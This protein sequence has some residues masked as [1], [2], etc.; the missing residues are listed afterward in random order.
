MSRLFFFLLLLVSFNTVAFSQA[1]PDSSTHAIT[2]TSLRL[3][4]YVLNDSLPYTD[5]LR[6]EAVSPNPHLGISWQPDTVFAIG[7]TQFVWDI[8]KHH[9]FL[10]FGASPNFL[11]RQETDM[12]HVTGKDW[13]FYLLVLLLILFS[14][15]K[16]AFP[17]YFSDLFRVFF[18]TT[19]KQRQISEQLAQTPFPSLLLN[20]FF[21]VNAGLYISLLFN[22]Y[23]I[24]PADNFW[25]L[26]LY[27]CL[28]L[29]AIYFVKFIGLKIAGWLFSMKEATYSY[30]FIVFVVNKVIG[31]ILFPFL[32]LLAFS[33]GN[34]YAASLTISWCMLAGMLA[35]RVILTFAAIRN[36]VSINP[37][38][39][40]LYL[41]AFEIAP[42][43]LIYKALLEILSIT[44]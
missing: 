43:L 16:N 5:S 18:R 25:L 20:G 14:F 29:A 7:S 41:V 1:A 12:H 3:Q 35:Y 24:N 19:L 39:F 30:I 10:G 2:D 22:H 34:V 32:I 26:F 15:L 28:G 44:P 27:C 36:Q 23:G 33:Q 38:H 37:F 4:P 8:L 13:L 31:I 42:L 9:P 21:I 11:I 6:T 17:K 40:F